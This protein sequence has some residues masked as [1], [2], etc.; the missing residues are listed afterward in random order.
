MLLT[1]DSSCWPPWS[2][3]LGAMEIGKRN[4]PEFLPVKEPALRHS[5]C[6]RESL[7]QVPK[8]VCSLTIVCKCCFCPIGVWVFRQF[9]VLMFKS[10][11]HLSPV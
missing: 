11:F 10:Y 1:A 5:G 7:A 2:T 9:I 6:W 4:I 8:Y 3:A